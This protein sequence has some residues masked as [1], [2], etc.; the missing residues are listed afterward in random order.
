MKT[1]LSSGMTDF[2]SERITRQPAVR[3]KHRPGHGIEHGQE[4]ADVSRVLHDIA[5]SADVGGW[6]TIPHRK[7]FIAA[8][9]DSFSG[10]QVGLLV[11]S[12]C[13]QDFDT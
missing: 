12:L 5:G 2:L 6:L 13:R 3:E 1:F 7:H 4:A 10:R 8:I 11:G 9:D